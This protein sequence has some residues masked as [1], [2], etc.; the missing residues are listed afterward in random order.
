MY[1]ERKLS[2]KNAQF[3]LSNNS[4]T[5]NLRPDAVQCKAI[6]R[7][8]SSGTTAGEEY[9]SPVVGEKPKVQLINLTAPA[10]AY[11]TPGRSC[12]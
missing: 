3:L 12:C 6:G 8:G 11:C 9:C 10:E 2:E 4:L 1:I 5:V 7:G